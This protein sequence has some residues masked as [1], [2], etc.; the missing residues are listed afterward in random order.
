[1]SREGEG[2]VQDRSIEHIIEHLKNGDYE[3]ALGLLK[4]LI[5]EDK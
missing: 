2:M 3:L 1:M 4:K 5:K